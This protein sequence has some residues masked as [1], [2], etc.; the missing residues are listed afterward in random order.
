MARLNI[1]TRVTSLLA[2]K[3][4]I[5]ELTRIDET[6]YK[7]FTDQRFEEREK[8]GERGGCKE[9]IYGGSQTVGGLRVTK[10]R[11]AKIERANGEGKVLP[12]ELKRREKAR[13]TYIKRE[14]RK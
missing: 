3:G 10:A 14:R 7:P 12:L 2:R 1:F 6:H 11:G 8:G 4:A 5:T 13:K 9:E